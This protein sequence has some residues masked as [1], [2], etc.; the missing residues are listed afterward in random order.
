MASVAIPEIETAR[1]LLRGA[2]SADAAPLA[3]FIGDPAFTRYIPKTTTVRTPQERAERLIG[4]YQARWEGQPYSAVGWS[5]VRKVDGQFIGLVGIENDPDIEGAEIDYRIGPPYFGQGYATEAARASLRYVIEQTDW[6]P[7]VGYVVREN[8]ASVRVI[9]RLGFTYTRDVNYL[10]MAGNPPNLVFDYT[11]VAG[12]ALPRAHYTRD[13]AP[14]RIVA[15][16]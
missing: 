10:E 14:Y 7:L 6:D 5:I 9:E 3:A 13:D 11:M 1:L 4:Q 15:Q 16:R 2:D 12:Y 8:A